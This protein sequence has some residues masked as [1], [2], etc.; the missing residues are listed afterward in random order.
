MGARVR[1]DGIRDS[2]FGIRSSSSLGIEDEIG[3]IRIPNAESR[4]LH[5]SRAQQVV[6]IERADHVIILIDD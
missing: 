2:E 5:D 3:L 1:K 6:N 4:L